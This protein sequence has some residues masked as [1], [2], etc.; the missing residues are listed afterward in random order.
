VRLLPGRTKGV[1]VDTIDDR[2]EVSESSIV[3]PA[4]DNVDE[5]K[6]TRRRYFGFVFGIVLG[7]ML[8]ALQVKIQGYGILPGLLIWD[9]IC[10]PC[11]CLHMA[12]NLGKP[13]GARRWTWKLPQLRTR[14]L[15]VLVAYVALLLGMWVSTERLGSQA[16][17]YY[18]RCMSARVLADTFRVQGHKAEEQASLKRKS[19][20]V[21]RSGRVPD[22]LDPAQK[23]FLRSLD[24]D[25]TL[26]PKY[27]EY[28]RGF[29]TPIEEL[30]RNIAERN[31]V[32][33]RGLV[34]YNEKLAAKYERARWQPWLPV[35][36]DPPMPPTY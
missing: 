3:A 6:R 29:I 30:M 27:R 25:S 17:D 35:E 13:R 1:F 24:A 2:I 21:L 11:I 8:T 19:V 33:F 7:F 28:R 12:H 9:L 22:S 26:T 23:E 14:T 15:M 10:F 5:R 31:A 34:D 18:Q 32:V 20:E 16:R 36:P 4:P